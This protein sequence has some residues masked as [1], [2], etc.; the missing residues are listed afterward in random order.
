MQITISLM[1]ESNLC[2]TRGKEKKSFR[3]FFSEGKVHHLVLKD[4]IPCPHNS[5]E[6][7]PQFFERNGIPSIFIGTQMYVHGW[8]LA[9]ELGS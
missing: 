7:D 4:K 9:R 1:A 3:V 5:C 2:K 8:K 6:K